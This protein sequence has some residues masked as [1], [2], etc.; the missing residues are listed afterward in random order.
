[1]ATGNVIGKV[2]VSIGN[3][4]FVNGEGR[5]RSIGYEDLMYEGEQIYSDDP[6]ALFQIRYTALPE[7]TAY[8]GVFRV[9]A[10]GSVISGL[11]GNE[12]LFGD[13]IDFMETAAGEGGPKE[14]SAFLEVVGEDDGSSL[15][16]FGRGADENGYGLG[17]AGFSKVSESDVINKNAPVSIINIKSI[18]L[19]ENFSFNIK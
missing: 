6:S 2:E 12:N 13:D 18:E 5:L 9:L 16:G 1:M 4:K 7:A 8:D 3:V 15:L 19:L 14:S 10:D 11:D 17:A